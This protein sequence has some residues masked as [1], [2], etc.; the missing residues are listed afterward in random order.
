MST[1]QELIQG[2]N[3]PYVERSHQTRPAWEDDQLR[4]KIKDFSTE[5]RNESQFWGMD[6]PRYQ[7]PQ[8]LR[9]A[10]YQYPRTAMK[11]KYVLTHVKADGTATS[12]DVYGNSLQEM[13]Q[14]VSKH[15]EAGDYDRGDKVIIVKHDVELD[16]IQL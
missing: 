2:L 3:N 12:R 11:Q 1:R 5:E 13:R 9:K 4:D 7:Y 16:T 14:Y 10:K 15:S 6:P 8:K